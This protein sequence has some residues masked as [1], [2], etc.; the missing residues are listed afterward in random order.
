MLY[1]FFPTRT[2]LFGDTVPI[3]L[4][5]LMCSQFVQIKDSGYL[6]LYTIK[7]LISLIRHKESLY[8][9]STDW[10][11][12]CINSQFSSSFLKNGNSSKGPIHPNFCQIGNKTKKKNKNKELVKYFHKMMWT[13]TKIWKQ[14]KC[15]S[16]SEWI[17]KVWYI[18]QP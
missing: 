9:S 3:K 6:D 5:Q 14:P 18:I 13:V 4:L 11:L 7:S 17:K 12:S 16:I 8:L 2:P 1:S 15:A 10:L